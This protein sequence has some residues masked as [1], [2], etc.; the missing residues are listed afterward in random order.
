[1]PLV[2]ATGAGAHGRVLLGLAVFGGMLAA[3]I[4][5][6]FL[7]PV[8]YYV[9]ESL[10]QRGKPHRKPTPGSP[11]PGAPKGSGDGHVSQPVTQPTLSPTH[12]RESGI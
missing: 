5:A 7:I 11:G 6:I 9:V 4:I 12:V 2:L 1:V 3:S 10:V 8:S